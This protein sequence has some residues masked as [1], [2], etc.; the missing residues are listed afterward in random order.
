LTADQN[1][2]TNQNRIDVIMV[3]WL[4]QLGKGLAHL[5]KHNIVHND[6]KLHNVM[7]SKVGQ[8][9]KIIDFGMSRVAPLDG[10][11]AW[12][13]DMAQLGRMVVQLIAHRSPAAMHDYERDPS[14]SGCE[15]IMRK[16]GA[17]YWGVKTELHRLFDGTMT[18]NDFAEV[19]EQCR[20]RVLHKQ[21]VAGKRMKLDGVDYAAKLGK[22]LKKT[23][24]PQLKSQTQGFAFSRM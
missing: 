22:Y 14:M 10:E 1:N 13:S 20:E 2:L 11:C 8:T 9:V 24:S 4:I 17:S 7:I 3:R 23:S 21:R 19:M 5:H 15:S 16:H 6:L 12:Q 18:A